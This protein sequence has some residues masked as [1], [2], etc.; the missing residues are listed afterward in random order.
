MSEYQVVLERE[1]TEEGYIMVEAESVEEAKKKAE[2]I[3]ASEMSWDR[4]ATGK[5]WS[6][7]TGKHWSVTGE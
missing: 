1:V 3:P 2:Q 6:V 7:T 4:V 5:H